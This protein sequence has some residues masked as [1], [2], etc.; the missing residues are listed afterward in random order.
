LELNDQGDVS[1][2]TSLNITKLNT[3]LVTALDE[4]NFNISM[5][6]VDTATILELVDTDLF[7]TIQLLDTTNVND[8]LRLEITK[9]IIDTVLTSDQVNFDITKLLL[10]VAI[11]L[12][13]SVA[14]LSAI[15][16]ELDTVDTSDQVRLEITKAL[17]DVATILDDP[18]FDIDKAL[19]DITTVTDQTDTSLIRQILEL[20]TVTTNDEVRLAIVKA[21]LDVVASSDEFN[22]SLTKILTDTAVVSDLID[23]TGTLRIDELDTITANDLVILDVTRQL[24]DVA[25]A[26][27]DLDLVPTKVF[28]DTTSV[29]D[30]V[31]SSKDSDVVQTEIV[32]VPD[33]IVIDVTKLIQDISTVQDDVVLLR[34]LDIAIIDTVLVD[35]PSILFIISTVGTGGAGTGGATTGGGVPVLQRLVGLSIESELFFVGSEDEVSAPSPF[36]FFN[37][38]TVVVG[39]EVPSDFII[40]TFGRDD[41]GVSITEIKADQAFESWFLFPSFPQPLDFETEV[42]TSRTISDPARF[43]NTALQ[44]FILTIPTMACSDVDPF[45][46]LRVPCI[47][48][49]LYEVPITF[50]I[51]K[52]GAVFDVKH[53]VTVDNSTPVVCDPI[54][55]LVDFILE[56]WWWLAG[57]LVMFMIMYFVIGNVKNRGIR[58]VRRINKSQFTSFSADQPKRK[59]KRGKR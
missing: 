47:D 17:T 39:N 53:I 56:S 40:S 25:S 55:Q 12:D 26:I 52:G 27:D 34:L 13:L 45:E 30:T 20:D 19:E 38:Q 36:S 21:I 41:T 28:I 46:S 5:G 42:D 14:E 44:D 50:T 33:D 31:D 3:D 58:T 16:E 1:D 15:I 35:D 29:S 10:D 32:S 11:V 59:F 57:I 37:P 23:A 4:T 7:T 51:S 54:C 8:D 2:V 6:L 48:P 43:Q 49:I 24:S 22:F 18:D 9:G